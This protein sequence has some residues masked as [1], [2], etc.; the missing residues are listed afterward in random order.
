[1]EM[2][3]FRVLK[4]GTYHIR[5][6]GRGH[7]LGVEVVPV[8]RREEYVVF[9]FNLGNS[10]MHTELEIWFN[11]RKRILKKKK[12]F[13]TYKVLCAAQSLGSVFL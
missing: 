4:R 7:F 12:R 13:L 9:D 1:M 6:K 8:D 5:V 11:N 10:H 3:V 2:R